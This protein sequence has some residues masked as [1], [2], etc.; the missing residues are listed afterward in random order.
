MKRRMINGLIAASVAFAVIY[1]LGAFYSCTLN[2]GNWSESAR[3]TVA[4]VGGFTC[5][6]A[7]MI[8][9]VELPHS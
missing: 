9:A 5:V 1:L 4:T 2:I 7:G 3:E 6:F 8:T